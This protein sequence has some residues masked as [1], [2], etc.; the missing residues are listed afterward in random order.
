MKQTAARSVEEYLAQLPE[1]RRAVVAA[2][3]DV[4][5]RHLPAGY[6]ERVGWG[7]IS[8]DVPLERFPNTYNGQ[9]LCY[10]AIAAQK[11]HYALYLLGAYGDPGVAEALRDGF[12]RAGKRLDMG[13]SCLRF[14][15]L[16]DLP[17]DVVARTIGAVPPERMM[18]LHEASHSKEAVAARRAARRTSKE[19]S[20]AG[21]PAAK[22][23]PA[24]KKPA[25][26]RKTARTK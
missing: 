1:D 2:V 7:M 25:A 18:A 6:Q 11:H 12:A 21:R 9:P 19:A 22:K 15:S 4:V 10:A 20:A 13:K 17:L 24:A 5:L 3:R 14:K 16:A 23:K 8:Y 26:K